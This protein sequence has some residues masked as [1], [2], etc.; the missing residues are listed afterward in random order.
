MAIVVAAAVVA[1]PAALSS[2]LAIAWFVSQVMMAMLLISRL[3]A[4]AVISMAG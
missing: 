1:A 3:N 4:R 2:F